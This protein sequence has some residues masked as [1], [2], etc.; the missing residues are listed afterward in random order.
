MPEG[1]ERGKDP[2]GGSGE[3]APKTDIVY[4]SFLIPGVCCSV[5]PNS[6]WLEFF[7]STLLLAC[8]PYSMETRNVRAVFHCITS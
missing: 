5:A 6:V 4:K 3:R 1:G 8:V 2:G 7:V